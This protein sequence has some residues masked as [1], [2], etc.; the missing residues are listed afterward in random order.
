MKKSFKNSK[1]KIFTYRPEIDGLR[2]IAVVSVIFYHAQISLFG[3]DPFKGG[4][5]GVDIFFV[6]SGYL[7]TSIIIKEI[8][9]TGTFSLKYFYERRV[10]RI[11]PPLLF[12]IICTFPLAWLY[13]LPENIILFSKSVLYSLGFASNIFFLNIGTQYGAPDTLY[14]PMLHTWSLAV[15]EQFYIL[16]PIFL[17]VIFKFLKR[18]IIIILFILFLLSLFSAEFLSRNYPSISFYILLT[19]IFEILAGSL[20]AYSQIKYFYIGKNKILNTI[21]PSIGLILIFFSIY[22]FDDKVFHP[23]TYTLIPI[24]GVCLI[25]WYSNKDEYINKLLSSK[26]FV[27]LGLISYSLYLWHYPVFAFARKTEY[28]HGLPTKKLEIAIIIFILSVITYFLI[29]KPARNQN[30]KFKIIFLPIFITSIFILIFSLNII[31]NNGYENRFPDILKTNLT[32]PP[33]TLL[34][35]PNDKNCHDWA[36]GCV[37]YSFKNKRI[38]NIIGDSQIGSLIYGLKTKIIEKGYTLKTSTIASCGF[39]PGFNLVDIKTQKIDYNCN[40]EYFSKLE[41]KLKKE[42][43]S[44]IIFGG[45]F[46]THLDNVHYIFNDNKNLREMEKWNKKYVS[47]GKYKNIK[48]SFSKSIEELSKKNKIVLIYPI[49]ET[50]FNLRDK[51]H[52][53]S[54]KKE[55]NI[56]DISNFITTSFTDYKNRTKSSFEFLDAIEGDNIYRVYPHKLFCGTLFKNRCISHDDKNIFY[57]D[58]MHLSLKGS[59]LINE[60]IIN[61]IHKINKKF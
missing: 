24:L 22:F 39:Y 34:K 49:P 51:L 10:R 6:I 54:K 20:I 35:T 41:T 26:I 19:R 3:Y 13:L 60:L 44:I 29:E 25:I 28:I 14:I 16:F 47:I 61:K 50:Q 33:W 1:K 36:R 8:L 23:S 2:A 58:R 42:R 59:E 53:L 15:E 48:S 4:F 45:N 56:N 17:I 27:S 21:M 31:K 38:V 18:K 46:Q 37:F 30:F 12:V 40:N 55:H 43:D 5:I 7:I 9:K 57:Y 11:I 32:D 52:I